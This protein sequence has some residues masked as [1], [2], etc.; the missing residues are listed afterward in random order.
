MSIPEARSAHVDIT[1][2]T[3]QLQLAS[4]DA[5]VAF[6]CVTLGDIERAH[7]HAITAR[8]AADAAENIIRAAL[9]ER[10]GAGQEAR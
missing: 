1:E 5:Q 9:A 7:I 3:R 2:A 6:D 8:A 4:H 10:D